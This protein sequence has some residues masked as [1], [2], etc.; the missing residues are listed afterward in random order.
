MQYIGKLDKEKLGIYKGKIVTESVI[1]TNERIEHIEK[2]HPGDYNKYINS[3]PDLINSPDYILEDKDKTDT[4]IFLK[5]ILKNQRNIEVVIKLQTNNME[6]EKC[7]TII[8]FWK[9][10]NV[11]YKKTI[12][13]NKI[14]YR[15]MDKIE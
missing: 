8:T 4:L 14:I 13:N 5:T 2:R 10:R 3:I 11:N 7:N 15:N 6:K 1:I 9:I 12:R